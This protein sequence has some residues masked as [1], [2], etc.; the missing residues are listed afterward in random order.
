MLEMNSREAIDRA[1]APLVL[2]VEDEEKLRALVVEY[3]QAGGYRTAEAGSGRAAL[4]AFRNYAPDL[5][6]LDL[7]LPDL[8]GE[9]VAREIR[10]RSSVAIIMLTAKVTEAEQ[11]AGL[12]VGADDY[13]TKPFSLKVLLARMEAVLR[14][15]AEH[16]PLAKHSSFGD[17]ELQI[18]Y[19]TQEVR[20]GKEV[21]VLTTSE[22]R[23]LS[24]LAARPGRLW[25]R[26]ELIRY[27][28]P[29]DFD[30]FDRAV[31]SHIKNLRSKLEADPRH[32][33]YILTVY[34]RGYKFSG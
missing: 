1:A 31:D 4:A 16:R 8:S 18:D 9:D 14:R 27:A 33:R 2:V 6:L 12:E 17:G 29:A 21:L 23:L 5:V 24:A 11:L 22:F 10:R 15:A 13:L 19:A 30:G 25:S 3:L 32:P 34:G 7:M 26:E 20:R 28:L